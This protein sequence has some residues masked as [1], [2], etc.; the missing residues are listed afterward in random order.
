[1]KTFEQY[2][3]DSGTG[4]YPLRTILDNLTDEEIEDS[5]KEYAKEYARKACTHQNGLIKEFLQ[6]LIDANMC[7][8]AADDLIKE[9][10]KGLNT[11][12]ILP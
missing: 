10:I 5:V 1:M 8:H 7:S 11:E 12:I 9:Y 3:H 4:G 6:V 2:L